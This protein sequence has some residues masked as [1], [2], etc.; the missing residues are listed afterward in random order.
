MTIGCERT[1]VL[2]KIFIVS[3][4]L[5]RVSRLN[6]QPIFVLV[7]LV[8]CISQSSLYVLLFKSYSLAFLNNNTWSCWHVFLIDDMKSQLEFI[9]G[10]IWI[11]QRY[12]VPIILAMDPHSS[13]YIHSNVFMT[14]NFNH[15]MKSLDLSFFIL[16][17]NFIYKWEVDQL[18]KSLNFKHM[19]A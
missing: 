14:K 1:N 6:T 7:N 5:I 16:I 2:F 9:H 10:N 17:Y 18:G 12:N 15:K 11:L 4:V 13:I 3:I 19:R 8:I